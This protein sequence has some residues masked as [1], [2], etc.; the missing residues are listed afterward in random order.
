MLEH[1]AACQ[2]FQRSC[3]ALER[4]ATCLKKTFVV[5]FRAFFGLARRDHGSS[6]LREVKTKTRAREPSAT[7]VGCSRHSP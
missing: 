2:S 4:A 7:S 3:G 6:R 5:M 1:Y